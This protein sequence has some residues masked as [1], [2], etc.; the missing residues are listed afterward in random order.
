MKSVYSLLI[1]PG[2]TR[3]LPCGCRTGADAYDC[4]AAAELRAEFYRGG[5]WG[6]VEGHAK[7]VELAAHRSMVK[8]SREKVGHP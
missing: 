5:A 2:P 7:G 3:R 4:D 8:V 1:A 6:A